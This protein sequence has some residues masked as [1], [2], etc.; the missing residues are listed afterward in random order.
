VASS[1]LSN[2]T[3][4]LVTKI[5]PFSKVKSAMYK[6]RNKSANLKKIYYKTLDDIEIP[7]KFHSFLLG[8][9]I[10][11]DIVIIIFCSDEA[12]DIMKTCNLF[13]GDGTFKSCPH[14]F[15]QLYTLH[16]DLGSSQQTTNIVPLVYAL[17]NKKSTEAYTALFSIVKSQIPEWK[18]HTFQSD[19]EAA[20]MG[21]FKKVFKLTSIKGCYFHFTQAIWK[22]G[23]ELGL[24]K[25]KFLRKQVAL[26]AV[27]PLLPEDKI[28]EGWFYI[29]SLS[30]DGEQSKKFRKYMLQFWLKDDFPKVWCVFGAK[31]RTT[32][33][34][35]GWHNK[36][37]RKINKKFPSL[38]RL[39][40]VLYEDNKISIIK[41]IQNQPSKPRN[42]T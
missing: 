20:A 14:P 9:F 32:N 35:E 22:K 31:H 5:P 41:S 8:A 40:N 42:N 13:F 26:S 7:E 27:L 11:E 36:L 33:A 37:N 39:L 6:Y 17:M 10:D 25:S 15:T 2:I 24:N 19:F 30:P 18:P 38:L 1:H 12:K 28:I 34:L 29:A 23:G 4:E 21:A 3:N 16:G